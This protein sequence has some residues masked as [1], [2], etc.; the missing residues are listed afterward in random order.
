MTIDP[1]CIHGLV[2]RWC[3]ACRPAP[4]KAHSTFSAPEPSICSYCRQLIE[5]GDVVF[6]LMPSG[7]VIHEYCP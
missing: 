2:V 3:S 6:T 4:A 7:E 5:P 1:T